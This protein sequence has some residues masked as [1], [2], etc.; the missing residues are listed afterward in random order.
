MHTRTPLPYIYV[1]DHD[2]MLITMLNYLGNRHIKKIILK[3]KN[4][5]FSIDSVFYL[6]LCG[7]TTVC[8]RDEG[9]MSFMPQG[10]WTY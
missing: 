5:D 10:N 1:Y 8:L 9:G 2:P 7:P 6:I 4:G 3:M